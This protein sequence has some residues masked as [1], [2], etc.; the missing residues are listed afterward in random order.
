M[1]TNPFTG[2]A[3]TLDWTN[4]AGSVPVTDPAGGVSINIMQ[5]LPGAAWDQYEI[6]GTNATNAQ[7]A[8]VLSNF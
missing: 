1:P 3:T 4:V 6:I 8:L 2:A 7:L 5:A